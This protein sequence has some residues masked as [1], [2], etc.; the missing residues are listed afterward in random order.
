MATRRTVPRG[1]K[2]KMVLRSQTQA[3]TEEDGAWGTVDSTEEEREEDLVPPVRPKGTASRAGAGPTTTFEG[4]MVE[5]FRQFMHAQEQQEKRYLQAL[6]T[7]QETMR[8]AIQ[9]ASSS[10]GLE[11]PRMELHSP[12]PRRTT[13]ALRVQSTLMPTSRHMLRTEPKLPSFQPG[14]DIEN[15][16]HRFEWLA[17]TCKWPEEEWSYQLVPLLTGQA[18]EA[19]LAMDED[20][21]AV[22]SELKKALLEKFNVSPETYRQ[23]FRATTTLVGETPS[24]TYNR[25]RHLYRRWVR[26]ELYTK[27]EIGEMVILEQFLRVLPYKIRIW[28]KEREPRTGP[29]AAKLAQQYRNAH[30]EGRHFHSTTGDQRSST[31][32]WSTGESRRDIQ[33]RKGDKDAREQKITS[34][35]CQQ[36]GH[37]ATVCPA[38]KGKLT[39]FCYVPRKEDSTVNCMGNPQLIPVTVNGKELTAFL[40]TGSS[41]SLVKR[42]HVTSFTNH[43]KLQCVHGDVKQYPQTEVNVNINGQ[44]YLLTVA[45]VET[46]PADV[47]LGR[48]VPVLP[49]LVQVNWEGERFRSN[50]QLA[51]P[52]VTRAQA[53]RG[54]QP[55]PDMDSSLLQGGT[56]G[57]RKSHRQRR[58]E[59]GLGTPVPDIKTEGLGVSGWT[60]PGN[61]MELQRADESLKP[62]FE[63]ALQAKQADMC[64]ERYVVTNDILYMQALNVT[65]LVVL[66]CCRP[67]VLHLAH[68]VPWAGHLALQKTYA[69]IS[70][71]FVWPSMYMDVQKYCTTCPTCQQTAAV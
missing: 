33:D 40:D 16:L 30:Q 34:Y 37:K 29:A 50:V 8:Q 39:G 60:V 70:S 1:R 13:T 17:R 48:D 20:Q 26:L 7:L 53:K 14:E 62:L 10:L 11:S 2:A 66:K 58:L 19:Y 49:E 63:K 69:C 15:Y 3:T 71:R 46:L 35:Y 52:A 41:M 61:I 27:E 5:V 25:L 68:T 24:E 57:P 64:G 23:R 21:A 28:V 18:L 32:G 45:I 6:Q 56:K 12:A 44:T 54:L 36:P 47:I 43:T 38:R 4:G 55:L 31:S 51:C 22:Y 42:C 65:R 59:K 67:V 9:P